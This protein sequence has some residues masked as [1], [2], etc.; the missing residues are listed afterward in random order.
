M[1][2]YFW[3]FFHN[4]R[5]SLTSPPF[6]PGFPS[7]A[8]LAYHSQKHSSQFGFTDMVSYAEAADQ[9]CGGKIAKDTLI[10]F[11]AHDRARVMYNRISGEFAFVHRGGF[12]GSYMRMASV[13]KG[14]R[15]FRNKCI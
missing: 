15:F 13:S 9:F 11:R 8:S 3:R 2:I 1:R 4:L 14:D 5:V 6:T 12:I 7:I 10:C